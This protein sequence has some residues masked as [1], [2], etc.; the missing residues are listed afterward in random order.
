MILKNDALASH[1]SL[2][3]IYRVYQTQNG[4]TTWKSASKAIWYLQ[5]YNSWSIGDLDDIGTGTRKIASKEVQ[6]DNSPADIEVDKWYYQ[7]NGW[8]KGNGDIIVQ[9]LND[10]GKIAMLTLEISANNALA[11]L[12]FLRLH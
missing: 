2:Q 7:N 3:G 10:K 12:Y 4:G 1:D 9:C 11:F 6:G 8:K 5:S